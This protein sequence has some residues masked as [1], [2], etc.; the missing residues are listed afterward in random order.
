MLENKVELA[1]EIIKQAE[2]LAELSATPIWLAEDGHL[3]GLIAL[4]D[5][6]RE[7]TPGAV[8]LLQKQYIEVVMCSGDSDKT[9]QA[10]A[11]E[12]GIREV[13]SQVMPEDK[14]N[15]IKSLQEQGYIVGMVGDGVNDAPALA[16]A[17]TGF[18]IG[19][20][21]DV[22]IENADITLAGKFIDECRNGYCSFGRNHEKY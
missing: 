15:I 3:L 10:V 18:A 4:K 19:S 22:A 20:G 2:T 7:D 9:A 6:I 16:Q 14:L 12:L 1:P 8:K 21:T 13:Y 17:N 11:R 5:P